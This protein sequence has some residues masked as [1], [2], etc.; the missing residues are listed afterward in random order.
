MKTE[1]REPEEYFLIGQDETRL[2]IYLRY[3]LFR[4]LED[5]AKREQR[6][7]VGLLVGRLSEEGGSS[8]V[9]VEDAIEAP[10]GDEKT[11]RFEESLWKRARRIAAARHPN[12][13][14]VG[15]FHTHLTGEVELTEEEST[16]HKRYF[17]E[18][19]HLLYVISAQAQDRNFFFRVDGEM[20]PARGFR[21]YGKAPVN[22]ADGDELVSVSGAVHG[23]N[24]VSANPEQQNR[25]LERN[26]EKI[27]RRL[28]KPP[29]APK[30]FL[31][32]FLLIVNGL[33][34]W[35][36]PNPPVEVDTSRLE[37]GQS[38]LSAQVSAVRGRIE[39]LERRLADVSL[40]DE[41]LK[42]AA[43]L[44][45]ISDP[46]DGDDGN[47]DAQQPKPAPSSSGTAA[48][49]SVKLTGGAATIKFYQVA[50][51]DILGVL[52]EKFYPDAPDGTL[53]AFSRFNRLKGDA[54]FPGDTLKIPE[55]E[56]LRTQ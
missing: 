41:Q 50:Q 53:K 22:A 49:D 4:A 6:E 44:E 35:F 55:L 19:T 27:Q 10:L 29:M 31:I 46:V 20:K 32:V 30:D 11:G 36:R 33:L 45:D 1:T 51:G 42:L 2:S 28:Q 18:D 23:I 7:Q 26:L 37:R 39:K 24:S 12:R 47:P 8:F 43:G 52:V 3:Q 13:I 25:Q 17:P 21:I 16:A 9:L 40:L 38:D 14:I 34:I 5:F 56:V 54:I 48:G 15:W